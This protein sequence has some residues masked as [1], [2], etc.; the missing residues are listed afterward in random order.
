MKMYVA[1]G[2]H[3]NIDFQ[4][5]LPGTKNYRSQ[6]I[7]IGGQIQISGDLSKEQI[8]IIVNHH[9]IYGMIHASELGA[10]KGFHIP[11][12][13]AVDVPVTAEI[14]A[15]LIIQNRQFNKQLG[16]RLRQEAAVAVSNTIEDN[17]TDNL[18]SL[19]MT[20]EELPS[21]ERDASFSEG[22]RVTRERD[23][24]APQDPGKGL[25]DFSLARKI[26]KPSF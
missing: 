25:L 13:F 24:G 10:F 4:Y 23:R 11:Y 19:E 15:E 8:D 7:P 1:N 12:V 21:K 26:I 16:E 3:Q 14:M 22:I 20:I 18:K 5:R 9:A 6:L 17:T 2:T